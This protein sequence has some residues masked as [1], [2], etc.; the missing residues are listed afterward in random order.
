MLV[1]KTQS[2][3]GLIEVLVALLV[4]A[5]GL[6]GLVG[7]QGKAQKAEVES[8]Q[9]TQALV[10][11]E[12]MVNRL[13]SNR[14]GRDSYVLDSYVGTGAQGA[15]SVTDQ[16]AYTDLQEWHQSL[17]GSSEAMSD[18]SFIGALIGA[19]GCITGGGNEFTV[20]V[21][22]QGIISDDEETLPEDDPRQTNTCAKD[23]YGSEPKRRI[24]SVPVQFYVS[25]PS[26]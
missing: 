8:Y 5:I 12:D 3:A 7:L 18:G 4:T 11:L 20:T 1:R 10:I 9:R 6:L 22:W 13:R 21:A 15:P 23:L 14:T 17:I 19:R 26:P 24:L 25:P 2:G 16:R